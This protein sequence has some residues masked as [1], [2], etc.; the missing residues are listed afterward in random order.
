MIETLRYTYAVYSNRRLRKRQRPVVTA[1]S[2]HC[3]SP[4]TSCTFRKNLKQGQ[5][6]VSPT[7]LGHYFLTTLHIT[8]SL[9][10]FVF[11]FHFVYQINTTVVVRNVARKTY[12]EQWRDMPQFQNLCPAARYGLPTYVTIQYPSQ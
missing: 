6:P 9:K 3:M 4:V 5:C 8:F 11:V 12:C 2:Y 1:R 10:T 7:V